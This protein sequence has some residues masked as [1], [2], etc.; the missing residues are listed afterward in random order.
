MHLGR[1]A[2]GA[3]ADPPTLYEMQKRPKLCNQGDA[4]FDNGNRTQP[5]FTC[6]MPMTASSL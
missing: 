5:F 2:V 1:T 4:K 3:K 6:K